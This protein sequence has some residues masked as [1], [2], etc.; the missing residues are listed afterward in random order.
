MNNI[1][2]VQGTEYTG[3]FKVGN[4]VC[5]VS[6]TKQEKQDGLIRNIGREGIISAIIEWNKNYPYRVE[7]SKYYT[8]P[9]NEA[10]LELVSVKEEKND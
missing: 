7:L 5:I 6:V 10:T 1:K 8:S 9:C 3:K 2:V 4:R